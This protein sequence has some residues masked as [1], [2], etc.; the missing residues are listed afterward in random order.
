MLRLRIMP[1]RERTSIAICAAD[2]R[3][4][5]KVVMKSPWFR[6]VLTTVV[7]S[8]P[9]ALSEPNRAV[10]PTPLQQV[11]IDVDTNVRIKSW[12]VSSDGRSTEHRWSITKDVLHGGRQE[13]VDRIRVDNGELA[14]DVI[15][16]RGMNIWDVDCGD[17]SLGWDSPVNEVVHPKFVN[18][19]ERRGLG[20]LEGFGGWLCRC[21]LASNGAPG[22]DRVRSNTGSIVPVQLT[23]HGKVNYLPARHVSVEVSADDPPVL[24]IRGVV[25]ETMMF[26]TQLRLTAEISTVVGSKSLTLRD[27]ITNLSADEQEFQT[28]YHTNFG[29]PLLEGGSKFLA[30]VARVTPRDPRAAEGDLSKWNHY[31][32]PTPGYNE[33]VYFLELL[34]DAKKQTEIML[35]NGAGTRGVSLNYSLKDL[36]HTTLWKNTAPTANG[37]VTG[38]EPAT[39]FPNLREFERE[40]G[41]V[42]R[43]KGGE[44]HNATITFTVHTDA[45]LVGAARARIRRLQGDTRVQIDEAPVPGLSP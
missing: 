27:T 24:K 40:N 26:G 15:P 28:L 34:A 3:T 14:F 7:V 13:D 20:W 39:N 42:P 23:L 19:R 43:L 5:R 31:L 30:P 9:L 32:A 1:A 16:T 11:L 35:E 36:P 38:L 37:Y 29:S 33:Q 4:I 41:R 8:T 45:S 6:I 22:E 12:F 10:N 44:S 21:G 2:Y 25:E 17:L 18:L